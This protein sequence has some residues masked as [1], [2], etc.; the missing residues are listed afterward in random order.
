MT[1][2]TVGIHRRCCR[3]LRSTDRSA[4]RMPAGGLLR[5]ARQGL[6]SS[7]SF[8]SSLQAAGTTPGEESITWLSWSLVKRSGADSRT[9]PTT[10]RG[11]FAAQLTQRSL[12]STARTVTKDPAL[13]ERDS[14]DADYTTTTAAPMPTTCTPIALPGASSTLRLGRPSG[15]C[16]P[17]VKAPRCVVKKKTDRP[18]TRV[19]V[20][21]RLI[22]VCFIVESID[23]LLE[24][25][26]RGVP[27]RHAQLNSQHGAHSSMRTCQTP[28]Q[29]LKHTR[30]QVVCPIAMSEEAPPVIVETPPEEKKTKRAPKESKFVFE[31]SPAECKADVTSASKSRRSG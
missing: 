19:F 14:T 18:S 31:S 27:E 12:Q 8:E 30:S 20:A 22:T 6:E 16:L 3:G 28:S 24:S 15:D 21:K 5:S 26:G 4:K 25:G 7:H 11:R 1:Q 9:M 13:N 17:R 23:T 29:G 10:N 2:D